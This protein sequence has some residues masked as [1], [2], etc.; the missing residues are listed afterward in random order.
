MITVWLLFWH[1]RCFIN[2]EECDLY[3]KINS[4]AR[5]PNYYVRRHVK[6]RCFYWRLRH[7][8]SFFFLFD[9]KQQ[10][11]HWR[12]LGRTIIYIERAG[13]T[14]RVHVMW[15]L[16]LND[17]FYWFVCSE[18]SY[19]KNEMKKYY[20]ISCTSHAWQQNAAD[21]RSE[22]KPNCCSNVSAMN[23][24]HIERREIFKKKLQKSR[25]RR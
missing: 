13:E 15:V 10:I 4:N 23:D 16:S 17:T 1:S 8:S 14:W 7:G 12:D 5:Q 6:Q 24:V 25:D 3:V 18:T 20:D 9:R 11:S 19:W 22:R 2:F 21:K